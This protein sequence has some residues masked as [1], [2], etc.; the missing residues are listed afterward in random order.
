ML[1]ISGKK[2]ELVPNKTNNDGSDMESESSDSED[3]E[4]EVGSGIP[5]LQV[6]MN[7]AVL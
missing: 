5:V 1:N 6:Y 4:E 7:K 2:R 3:D